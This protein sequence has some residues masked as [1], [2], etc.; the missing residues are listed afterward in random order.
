M[1]SSPEP[2]AEASVATAFRA[3]PAGRRV[4]RPDQQQ[5]V[6]K[7]VRHLACPHTRGHVAS[8][9]GTGKTLTALRTA[10]ALDTRHL[11]VG[12]HLWT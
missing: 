6:D 12:C 5:A 10:E 2:A 4:L 11:L 8:A 9:C 1:P 7:A 3:C